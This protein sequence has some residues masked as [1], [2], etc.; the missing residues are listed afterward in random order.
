[1]EDETEALKLE[2]RNI[3]HLIFVAEMIVSLQEVVLFG[4]RKNTEQ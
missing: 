4:C 3:Y 2:R 1:M